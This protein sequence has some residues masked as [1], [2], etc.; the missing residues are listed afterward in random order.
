MVTSNH[1][2]HV[3]EEMFG[4]QFNLEINGFEKS[5]PSA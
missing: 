1:L 3:E 5:E 4:R 2:A